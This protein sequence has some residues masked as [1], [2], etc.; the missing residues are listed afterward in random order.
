MRGFIEMKGDSLEDVIEHL[1]R[2]KLIACKA[3]KKLEEYSELYN[4]EEDDEQEEYDARSHSAHKGKS[5][6]NY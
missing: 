5:R 3:M 6:Y 4:E 1:G 2:I